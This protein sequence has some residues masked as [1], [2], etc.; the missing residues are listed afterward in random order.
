MIAI[1]SLFILIAVGISLLRHRRVQSSNLRYFLWTNGLRTLLVGYTPIILF[2]FWQFLHKNESGW[3]AVM[4]AALALVIIHLAIAY[5]YWHISKIAHKALNSGS[6]EVSLRWTTVQ[7]Q[8]KRSGQGYLLML[9]A[10]Q[11]ISA[12]FVAFAQVRPSYYRL[13]AMRLS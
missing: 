2:I 6:E 11:F 12:A 7:G 13:T 5:L 10:A 1:C 4:I 3:L 9:A 8:F